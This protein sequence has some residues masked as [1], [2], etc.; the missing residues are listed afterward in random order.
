MPRFILFASAF[1]LIACGSGQEAAT[2]QAPGTETVSRPAADAPGALGLTERQL[3]DA[4]L[5][6]ANGNELGDVEGLVRTQ[7]GTVTQLL[8]EIEDS[9]P[10]RYVHVPV[11]GL[12]IARDRDDVDLRTAMSRADLMALPEVR[13]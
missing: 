12:Q 10:D 2:S 11:E 8:I 7:G 6:D 13:R 3:L 5:I 4:D 1:G 9:S